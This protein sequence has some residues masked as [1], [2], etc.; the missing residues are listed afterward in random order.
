MT[1]TGAETR[2]PGS[3]NLRAGSVIG[4]RYRALEVLG[5]GA[6]GVVY[7][8]ECLSERSEDPEDR[9]SEPG[10][11]PG[12]RV[13]LKVIHRHLV[14][15]RQISQRFHREAR[16]LRKLRCDNLV[17]LLDTGE[18]ESGVPYMA[19]ELCEGEPL[20]RLARAGPMPIERAVEII[21]QVCRALEVAHTAGVVH[22]DL[23]PGN[24]IIER[25]PEGKDRARVL[26][27]G[28]A[29]A[30]TSELSQSQSALTEQNMVFGTPEYMAP[31][32]ARGDEVDAR[33]DVY[34]AGVMLYELITGKVPFQA[35][36][37]IGTMTAHLVQ[38][39]APPSSQAQAGAI[40]PALEAVVL[41]ALA[42]RREDRYPSASAL[43]TALASA[44]KR[45]ADVASTAP[46]PSPAPE[47]DDIGTRDTE[48]ALDAGS[49]A[50]PSLGPEP[51][52][53]TWIVVAIVAALAGIAI[54]ILFSLTRS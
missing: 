31:E 41:H 1:E 48:L 25:T 19:I 38:E 22:R 13:A 18:D 51:T 35:S 52:S 23:K 7:V 40:P 21:R 16:I 43:A 24:V 27:F 2:A 49:P 26:D 5:E 47:A 20:D 10:P 11:R 3:G 30:L 12:E 36:T 33:C 54:G 9:G 53:R 46:P 34:A 32:Q 42:K 4:G 8:A 17:S 28:M 37:P 15:D 39:P 29:K 45:P 50:P 6:S 14:R 44:L